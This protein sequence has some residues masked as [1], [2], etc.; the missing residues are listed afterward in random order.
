MSSGP[1]HCVGTPTPDVPAVWFLGW[2][3]QVG[4]YR[5]AHFAS[6][7]V[8]QALPLLGLWLDRT[9]RSARRV[10]VAALLWTALTLGLFVQALMG[11]PVIRL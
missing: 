8:F 9:G 6:I 10:T 2:S 4:D 1:G 11:L 7:H 3:G 5:P